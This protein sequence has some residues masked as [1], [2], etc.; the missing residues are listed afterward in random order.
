MAIEATAPLRVDIG[1]GVTDIPEFG[2]VLGTSVANIGIELFADESFKEPRQIT[3]TSAFAPKNSLSFNHVEIG[4]DTN[5]PKT[6]FVRSLF[7][8]CLEVLKFDKPVSLSVM[9]T[10]PSGTGLGGSATLAL[11]ILGSLYK[12][13]GKPTS[14]NSLIQQAHYF[15]TERQGIQ[16]GFQDYIGAYFGG[17]NYIDFPSLKSVDLDD[18]PTLGQKV[19]TGLEDYLNKSMLFIVKRSENMSSGQIVADEVSNFNG[20]RDL[21]LPYLQ[22]I[23]DCNKS[24]YTAILDA[25]SGQSW[26]GLVDKSW[27]AQKRLSRFIGDGLM[28]DIEDSLQPIAKALRGPGAGGNSL[29]LIID[30]ANREEMKEALNRFQDQIIV[31]YGRVKRD[32]LRFSSLNASAQTDPLLANPLLETH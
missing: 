3:A 7:L 32:G 20:D 21:Y 23:K 2:A 1:G 12:L 29:M 16:G 13:A 30:Q 9:N 17:L 31:L 18:Y 8:Y 5:D 14:A 6:D 19:P 25:D 10:L 27:E 11:V 28:G 26:M 24:I 4:L 22:T 15:E